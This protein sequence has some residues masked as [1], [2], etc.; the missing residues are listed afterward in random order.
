M[1]DDLTLIIPSFQRQELTE[2]AIFSVCRQSQKCQIIVVD[3]ASA[4]PF[5]LPEDLANEQGIKIVRH[6]Q[7]KG[8][9]AARNTGILAA[10][11][12]YITFLDSDDLWKPNKLEKQ[13]NF[14]Q[15]RTNTKKEIA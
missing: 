5:K 10:S 8:A 7:N 6:E 1:T 4:P 15:K 14:M 3:D 2:R 9:A 11:T 12:T 13:I